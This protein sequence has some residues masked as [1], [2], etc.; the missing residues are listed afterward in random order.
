MRVRRE[1]QVLFHGACN[2]FTKQAPSRQNV[3][4][5]FYAPI[6]TKLIFAA[7]VSHFMHINVV[8]IDV[9]Y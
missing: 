9:L 7:H 4:G 5:T 8:N 6:S 2:I 3:G 1:M